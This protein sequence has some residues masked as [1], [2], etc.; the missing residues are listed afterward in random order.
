VIDTPGHESFSNMRSRGM[1]LCDIAVV[2]VDIMHGLE[3]QTVETLALLKDRNVRFIVVLNKVDRLC[4]WKHCP[5]APIK[6]ALENQSGDVKREFGWRLTKVLAMPL[7]SLIQYVSMQI[8]SLILFDNLTHLS[9]QVVTQLKE[10]GF[11]TALYYDNQKFRKVF[12]IVPTSAIRYV[13]YML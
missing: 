4:G 12:D 2:V 8:F 5:D 6:K 10:N 1:S 7:H 9:K 11:N 3:K 13:C